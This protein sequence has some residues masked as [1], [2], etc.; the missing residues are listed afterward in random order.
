MSAESAA[1][2]SEAEELADEMEPND[3]PA[4]EEEAVGVVNLPRQELLARE[5]RPPPW[6]GKHVSRLYRMFYYVTQR[7]EPVSR[8]NIL[9]SRVVALERAVGG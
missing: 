2:E 3:M 4:A 5:R 6:L 1:V 9:F 8:T 7:T